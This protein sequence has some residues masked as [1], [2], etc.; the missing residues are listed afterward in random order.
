MGFE[1]WVRFHRQ[2]LETQWWEIEKQ[3]KFQCRVDSS[4]GWEEVSGT[5]SGVVE[6]KSERVGWGQMV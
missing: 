1:K 5:R 2:R 3:R 6:K 4:V